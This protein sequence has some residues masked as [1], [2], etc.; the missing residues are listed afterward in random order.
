MVAGIA[1]IPAGLLYAMLD[2][3]GYGAWWV[4]LAS[5]AAG[6]WMASCAW[7]YV[8][9]LFFTKEFTASGGCII[10]WSARPP[11]AAV[12]AVAFCLTIL[13]PVGNAVGNAVALAP[14][15]DIVELP[16]APRTVPPT[17]TRKRAA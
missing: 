16:V 3:Y 10:T 14:D 12:A 13:P 1:A 5:I 8:D 6:L 15:Q 4:A 2:L 11:L 7:T 17:L 9:R